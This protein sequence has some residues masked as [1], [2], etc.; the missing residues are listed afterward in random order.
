LI[1]DFRDEWITYTL[2]EHKR[3][4]GEFSVSRAIAIEREAVSAADFTIAVTES[5]RSLIRQRHPREPE[6]KFLCIP[7]GY[8]PEEIPAPALAAGS[9]ERLVLCYTGTIDAN[10]VYSARTFIEAAAGLPPDIRSRLEIWLAG[11]VERSEAEAIDRA[12]LNVRRFGF[13]PRQ[14]ALGKLADADCALLLVNTR[15]AHSGKVFEYMALGK[16]ILALTVPGGELDQLIRRL[17]AGW[18]VDGSSVPA[19]RAALELLVSLNRRGPAAWPRPD[20]QAV[21]EYER[22]R[23]VRRM[24]METGIGC[25][26]SVGVT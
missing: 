14:D 2:H 4:A 26:V 20:A 16:P 22:P 5:W 11:R 21:R 8:D 7:N 6:G 15:D 23:L 24:A 3:G 13:L 25:P 1:N 12:P 18:C 10:P 9:G 19:I 17:L